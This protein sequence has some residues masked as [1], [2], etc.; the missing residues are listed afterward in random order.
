LLNSQIKTLKQI[1]K[2]SQT[3]VEVT[4]ASDSNTSVTLFR[5]ARLGTFEKTSVS[6]KPG[7]YIAAGTRA[8][9]RDVR[10]EFTVTNKDFD[11]P[12]TISCNEAI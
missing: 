12:I 7:R 3:P 2:A 1:I 11:S 9:Y 10:I 4:L 5:V 6:L 8:G